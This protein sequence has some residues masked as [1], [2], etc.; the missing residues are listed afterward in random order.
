VY[1]RER[2]SCGRLKSF[3]PQVSS[4]SRDSR[5]TH[6][7][8]SVLAAYITNPHTKLANTLCLLGHQVGNIAFSNIG[9]F[10]KI[11]NFW[12]VSKVLRYVRPMAFGVSFMSTLPICVQKS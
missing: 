7:Y 4:Q 2:Q 10:Q 1:S 12:K 8:W 3:L 9:N 6:G 5:A 11:E